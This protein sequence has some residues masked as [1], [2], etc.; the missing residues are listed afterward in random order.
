MRGRCFA[1]Q[2]PSDGGQQ[3]AGVPAWVLQLRQAQPH[4]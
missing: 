1:V 3:V 2:R 4:V